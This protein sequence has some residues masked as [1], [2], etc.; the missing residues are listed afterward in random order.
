M[1]VGRPA[2][3]RAAW[4]RALVAQPSWSDQ[5]IEP[6]WADASHKYTFVRIDGYR[7]TTHRA[8]L[9][10]L[11]ELTL[12]GGRLVTRHTCRTKACVNPRHLVP[13]TQKENQADR[14][15]DGTHVRSAEHCARISRALQGHVV[16]EATRRKI[17]ETRKR[18]AR[19]ED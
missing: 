6:P 3:E 5:C 11:G 1:A 2:P 15:R 9:Y 18:R 16:T 19:G 17:S 4:V 10:L 14:R 7:T 12:R 13:G 8:V